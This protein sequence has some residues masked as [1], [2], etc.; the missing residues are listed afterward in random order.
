MRQENLLCRDRIVVK[1]SVCA[2]EIGL[3]AGGGRKAGSG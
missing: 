2:L 1:Q 3:A